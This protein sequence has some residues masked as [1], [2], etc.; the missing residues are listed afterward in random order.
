[1]SFDFMLS[2]VNHL[3]IIHNTL[4][5]IKGFAPVPL[6]LLA[7]LF[8]MQPAVCFNASWPALYTHAVE[9]MSSLKLAMLCAA[10][11]I[12]SVTDLQA[13]HLPHLFFWR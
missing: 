3:S 10:G 13:H 7:S 2:I 4:S 8:F 9:E 5:M 12:T 11:R 6:H 1:M